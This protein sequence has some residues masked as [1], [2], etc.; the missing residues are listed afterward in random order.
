MNK[1]ATLG[2]AI[3]ALGITAALPSTVA[4]APPWVDHHHDVH[5]D[6][7]IRGWKSKHFHDH[8]AAH[9]FARYLRSLGCSVRF[10]HGDGHYDVEYTCGK[11]MRWF[12]EDREAHRFARDLRR[13]GFLARVH[14]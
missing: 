6:Y 10:E 5:V 12:H 14:H 3:L 9:D 4:A 1:F 2:L 8:E 13:L 11:G 7:S